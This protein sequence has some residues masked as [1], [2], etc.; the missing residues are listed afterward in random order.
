VSD[1]LHVREKI[2]MK[3]RR[4]GLKRP[5][6]EQIAG[7]DLH[8]KTGR[9]MRLHRVIDRIRNWYSER[10]VDPDTGGRLRDAQ[11]WIGSLSSSPETADFVPPP[12][13]QVPELLDSIL[14]NWNAAVPT[15]VSGTRREQAELIALFHHRFVSLHPF[16]D[17]NG[18]IGRLLIALQGKYFTGL[19]PALMETTPQYYAALKQADAGDFEHLRQL[20]VATFR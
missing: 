15:L 19:P 3:G 1:T 12:P 4:P 11:V 16:L 17:G 18:I 9:W 2:G 20:V 10:V 6:V 5:F 13:E 14:Q 7:D 8:R